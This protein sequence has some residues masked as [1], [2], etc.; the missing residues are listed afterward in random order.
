VRQVAWPGLSFFDVAGSTGSG[1]G[2][3]RAVGLVG[4]RP[5]AT[6]FSV[7]TLRETTGP[8]RV[9]ARHGTTRSRSSVKHDPLPRERGSNSAAKADSIN[10]SQRD[11]VAQLS[12]FLHRFG[13]FGKSKR[14]QC[15]QILLQ[16]PGN[17]LAYER[18]CC[19][20][21][22]KENGRQCPARP[23]ARLSQRLLFWCP[24][25]EKVNIDVAAVAQLANTVFA[26]TRQ[27]VLCFEMAIK[28]M[29]NWM[30]PLFR[31]QCDPIL[32]WTHR[33][34]SQ[35]DL[36]LSIYLEI[37][38]QHHAATA[39]GGILWPMVRCLLLRCLPRS[40]CM[41][42]WD[43]L[44]LGWKEP[45]LLFLAA[46][47]VVRCKRAL[48]LHVSPTSET[49]RAIKLIMS[50]TQ[51]E[52]VELLKEFQ[53]LRN[54]WKPSEMPLEVKDLWKDLQADFGEVYPTPIIEATHV[55]ATVT[56][57]SQLQ[58]ASH[59]QGRDQETQTDA[60][61]CSEEF[62]RLF[63][64]L[65]TTTLPTVP[66][67]GISEPSRESQDHLAMEN[68]DAEREKNEFL[69]FR[70]A[71]HAG[72]PDAAG[73]PTI[74]SNVSVL[75]PPLETEIKMGLACLDTSLQSTALEIPD[76]NFSDSCLDW[77]A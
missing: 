8:V 60:V 54:A 24:E 70:A 43:H 37:L 34:L 49:E 14:P 11:Q 22:V 15:W 2:S 68:E 32:R 67:M 19:D 27:E 10:Q 17:H 41:V 30:A 31:A 35:R 12:Q 55:E 7:K 4:R 47:A 62:P 57:R 73:V 39:H 65:D 20:Q 23:N 40:V 56:T 75:P 52:P 74:P 50:A 69:R 29:M 45:W 77:C 18:L 16:L 1:C 3:P 21:E 72:A 61:S 48:L 44:I 36:E 38:A 51:T 42:L 26:A 76:M 13:G 53:A 71:I 28:V 5:A 58:E 6:M 25:V 63:C 9:N 33:V 64:S 59:E 66:T 46:V